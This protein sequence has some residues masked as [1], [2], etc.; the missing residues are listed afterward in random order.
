[1]KSAWLGA[2]ALCGALTLPVVVDAA[3]KPADKPKDPPKTEPA[4][5]DTKFASAKDVMASIFDKGCADIYAYLSANNKP[6]DADE[7]LGWVTARLGHVRNQMSFIKLAKLFLKDYTKVDDQE[8]ADA[9]KLRL[10]AAQLGQESEKAEAETALKKLEESPKNIDNVMIAGEARLIHA[11]YSNNDKLAKEIVGKLLANKALTEAKS[12][13]VYRGLQ[14]MVL[15]NSPAEIKVGN[16]FPCW[17]EVMPVKDLEGK[18]IKLADFKGK[19]VLVD[20]WATWC[21]TSLQELPDLV[22]LYDELNEQ[23]F[24]IIGLSY[25]D[26]DSEKTLRFFI[27][28]NVNFGDFQI[29]EMKWRQV[30]DG[31]YQNCGMAGRYGLQAPSTV[32]IGKDGKVA[33]QN[34]RGD[35]LAEKIRELL[36]K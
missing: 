13:D 27:G 1:M 9:W 23:G 24:E 21:P 22:S 2:L 31:G 3:P 7:L 36:T 33:A 20:F 35:K 12:K 16:A 30:F 5:T 18:E 17:S 4:K 28:G 11:R 6:A 15:F 29:G 10:Y 25:D 19:V 8:D 34:L 14:R 26:E 32:L